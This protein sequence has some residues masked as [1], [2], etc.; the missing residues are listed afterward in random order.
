MKLYKR[1][2]LV[3][4]VGI[5]DADYNVIKYERING[6]QKRVWSCPFYIKWRAMLERCYSDLYHDRKPTYTE[7]T[8][9]PQW[10]TFSSF[11]TWMQTQHW[12][13]KE[14]DKDILFPGNKVY[15][16]DTCVFVG[17]RLNTFSMKMLTEGVRGLWVL[18]G[19]T[20]MKISYLEA[21]AHSQVNVS[22]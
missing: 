18:V 19:A 6:K 9:I 20:I 22:I 13:G 16:P 21:A 11:K 8:V 3:F 7:C 12:E 5:N 1:N 17:K 14:L 10:F 15:G 2:R 4:G